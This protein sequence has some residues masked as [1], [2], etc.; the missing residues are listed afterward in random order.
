MG[1]ATYNINEMG[2][3]SVYQDGAYTRSPMPRTI[4]PTNGY[5]KPA[6]RVFGGGMMGV[7]GPGGVPRFQRLATNQASPEE[8]NRPRQN[9]GGTAGGY[10]FQTDPGYEFR[11]GEGQR[12]L[13]R[14]AASAGGLLSG[15]YARRAIRYGQ[16]YA[17]N[18]YTNVYN[19]IANIA[20]L[21]QVSA[22]QSGNAALMAGANMGNAAGAAGATRASQYTAQGNAWGNAAYQIGQLPWEEI[23]RRG[24]GGSGSGTGHPRY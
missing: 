21:G 11:L 17:S 19:R 14:G 18:E 16:D 10:Q 12:V 24:S 4:A 23:F 15:G 20:G 8:D 7:A 5:V 13:E 3:E 6:G 9:P 22:G 1:D 2:P